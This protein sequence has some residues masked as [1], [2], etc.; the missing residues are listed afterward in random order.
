MITHMED[1]DETP[2]A[3]TH[4]SVGYNDEIALTTTGADTL[5]D[6]DDISEQSGNDLGASVSV[7][8]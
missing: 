6:V 7:S 1:G 5:V 2:G 4:D 3:V 8:G